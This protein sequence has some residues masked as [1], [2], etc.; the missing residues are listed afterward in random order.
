LKKIAE[1]EIS[2]D[3]GVVINGCQQEA[4][5]QDLLNRLYRTQVND[6]PKFFKMDGLSKLGFLGSELLLA[7]LDEERFCPREDRAVILFNRS[8]S[9]SADEHYQITISDADNFFPSPSIFVYTLPNIVTGEIAIRNKYYG[10]TAFYVIGEKDET[11]MQRVVETS[12]QDE[13][14]ESILTGWIDYF[15]NTHFEAQLSIIVNK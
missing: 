4:A 12:F 11:L 7:T 8:G 10:E 9:I 5:C 2:T 1:I 3:K 15:D 6:Y 13:S 14:T